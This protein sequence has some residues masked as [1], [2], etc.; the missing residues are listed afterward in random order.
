M[1]VGSAVPS[2]GVPSSYWQLDA[3]PAGV[4]VAE[5]PPTAEIAVIGGGLL[6]VCTA[7]WLARTGAR[8]VLIE[9]E[10]PGYGATG[11]NGGFLTSGTAEGYLGATARLGQAA[12][13]AVWQLTLDNRALVRQVLAEEQIECHY[14]EPGHISLALDDEQ[15]AV[16]H[17]TAAALAADGF[18]GVEVLDRAQVQE[19]IATPLGPLIRGGLYGAKSG[20]L[21]S[22][23]FIHGL[24]RAA[25]RHGA[26][27]CRAEVLE[28][29]QQGAGV[30]VTTNS[31]T[32]EARALVVAANAWTG[33]VLPE[34]A[35]IVT[36]VRGQV[37]SYVPLPRV[38]E[39][40]LG[41]GLTATGEYWQQT[42]GG[43]IVLGG[44]RAVA[45][46]KDVGEWRM[47]PTAV[48]QD[49]IEGVLPA[50]FPQLV[51]LRVEH[52]WAGLMGFTPDYLPIADR[53]PETP[54]AWVTGGFCGHGMP[55]GMRLGQLLAEAALH[56][57][58][59]AALAPLRLNRP[60]LGAE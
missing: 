18:G 55:F 49:A 23:R 9:R 8:P 35:G 31:G 32:I 41:A 17:R 3:G 19:V 24:A 4:E 10:T 42:L 7:Y 50:L 22:A 13:R 52:R 56:D 26:R 54:A 43:A 59:P 2:D 5:L 12:A 25:I 14:R 6:G 51:G 20:L 38:F 46:N 34:L 36:P 28:I 33:R 11:R 16:M 48:V 57:E 37:L 53:A 40:G 30:C 60:S 44:C 45:P 58:A 21:H 47:V 27:L 15:L 29:T 1:A 39:V